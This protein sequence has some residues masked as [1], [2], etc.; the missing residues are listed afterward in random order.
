LSLWAR[1]N[2]I[3]QKEAQDVLTPCEAKACFASRERVRK[4]STDGIF[5]AANRK[6]TARPE[7]Y[8]G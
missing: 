6:Q 3:E 8:F 4:K 7:S 2:N 5:F 1:I